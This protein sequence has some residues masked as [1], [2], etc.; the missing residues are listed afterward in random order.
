MNH[1]QMESTRNDIKK[2]KLKKIENNQLF[3]KFQELFSK[4]TCSEYP[5][6]CMVGC[7]KTFDEKSL[8]VFFNVTTSSK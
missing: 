6:S 5:I 2:R 1:F 8:Q 7:L 3:N 4:T